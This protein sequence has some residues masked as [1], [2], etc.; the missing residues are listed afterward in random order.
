MPLMRLRPLRMVA[1]WESV[2][3]SRRCDVFVWEGPDVVVYNLATQPV[4]GPTATL[5]AI[6]SSVRSASPT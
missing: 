3:S 4:P 2:C 5:D 1:I 6:K